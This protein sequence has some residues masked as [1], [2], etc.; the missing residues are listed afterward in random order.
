MQKNLSPKGCS[1][2]STYALWHMHAHTYI[3]TTCKSYT[4]ANTNTTTN[5]NTYK[6]FKENAI[7]LKLHFLNDAIKYTDW[8]L[9]KEKM[10]GIQEEDKVSL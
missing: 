3:Y 1:L 6:N 8:G 5:N 4:T 7:N 2:P 10:L 9:I